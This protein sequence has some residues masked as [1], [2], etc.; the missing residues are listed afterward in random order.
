VSCRLI[1]SLQ[2]AGPLA[3]WSSVE[4]R[5]VIRFLSVKG[6]VPIEVCPRWSRCTEHVGCHGTSVS[7]VIMLLIMAGEGV[8]V[9]QQP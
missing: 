2:L 6:V 5:R 8:D 7:M 3:I 4:V 9:K 1:V